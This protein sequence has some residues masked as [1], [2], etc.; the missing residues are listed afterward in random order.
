MVK[1][2]PQMPIETA[3][4]A[5]CALVACYRPPLQQCRDPLA[6]AFGGGFCF[7]VAKLWH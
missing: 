2:P 3:G 1:I 5:R 4:L 6:D 7:G